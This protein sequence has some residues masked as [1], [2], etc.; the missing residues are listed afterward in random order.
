[1]Q[2][3]ATVKRPAVSEVY[4]PPRV[5][6]TARRLGLKAGWALDLRTVDE[7]GRNWDFS[8]PDRRKEALCLVR[9]SQPKMLIGSPMCTA[10]SQLQALNR[11]KLGEEKWK[12]M[13]EDATRHILQRALPRA[14][15]QG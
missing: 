7:H 4:S 13:I 15:V 2:E 11:S 14:D 1:M 3:G 5:T 6:K 12:L 8:R 10:F 9:S